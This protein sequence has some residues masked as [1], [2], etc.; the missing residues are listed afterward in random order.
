MNSTFKLIII[1]LAFFSTFT[2]V[3][4]NPASIYS[5]DS[6]TQQELFTKLTNESRC[7]VCQNQSLADSAAPLA[8]DLRDIIY[9]MVKQGDDDKTIQAFLV[10]RYGNYILLR[11]PV[12]KNTWLLWTLPFLLLLLGFMVLVIYVRRR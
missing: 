2:L 5:F 11:P 10:K 3:L 9:Q 4:A 6:P 1:L 12:D 8:V 7:V